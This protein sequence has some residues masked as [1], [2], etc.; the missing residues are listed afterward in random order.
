MSVEL[1][2]RWLW[3]EVT[4]PQSGEIIIDPSN[5]ANTTAYP[6]VLSWLSIC[7]KVA[8][9]GAP[10][11]DAAGGVV[12]RLNVE[13]GLTGYSDINLVPMVGTAFFC[14]K[15]FRQK[16]LGNASATTVVSA[17]LEI[18]RALRIPRDGGLVVSCQNIH[19]PD[20][21]V[22]LI[23]PSIVAQ[24][25]H[26]DSKIPG[27]LAGRHTETI[28]S[29]TGP[30]LFNS[31][32]LLNR[33]REDFIITSITVTDRAVRAAGEG[34]EIIP[35]LTSAAWRINP[36]TGVEWMPQPDPIPTGCLSPFTRLYDVYDEGPKVYEFP[37]NVVLQPRQ[38]LGIKLT[39]Q[40]AA[41]Q[42]V[43]ICLRGELEV[44]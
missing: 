21:D 20:D 11:D 22:S 42:T 31:S 23:S 16:D 18:P 9:A 10:Y 30:Q 38:R 2:P 12:R 35:Q 6:M 41:A 39:E 7:G 27:V 43:Y 4:I 37:K 36:V 40:S 25:Y 29:A 19:D 33:G 14:G 26:D 28:T 1:V 17:D 3:Q 15:R 13:V 32:D 24:G 44:E 8:T 34:I 5:F